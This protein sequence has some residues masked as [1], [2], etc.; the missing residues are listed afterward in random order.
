MTCSL[1]GSALVSYAQRMMIDRLP[2]VASI[3]V[4]AGSWLAGC[5]PR[6]PDDGAWTPGSVPDGASSS[7]TPRKS[8]PSSHSSSASSASSAA[9]ASGAGPSRLSPAA[10]CQVLL[11]YAAEKEGKEVTPE[12]EKD[13]V[14]GLTIEQIEQPKKYECVSTCVPGITDVPSYEACLAK[15]L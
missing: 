6:P 3:M 15:C 2:A 9:S 7:A 13:C 8:T 10:M 12:T 5:D 14:S 11:K 4:A 1:Y